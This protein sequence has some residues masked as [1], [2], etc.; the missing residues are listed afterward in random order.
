M[1][2]TDPDLLAQTI[3][4]WRGDPAATY[5]SWFLW[6]ERIKNFRSIRR[7]LAQISAEIDAGIGRRI[8]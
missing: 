7:G 1:S 2:H 6:E 5:R 4:R 3:E 8:G